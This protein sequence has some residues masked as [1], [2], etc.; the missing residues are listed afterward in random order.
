LNADKDIK[1]APTSMNLLSNTHGEQPTAARQQRCEAGCQR[2]SIAIMAAICL[3]IMV[4]LLSSI[5]IGYLFYMKRDLQKVADLAALAGAQQLVSTPLTGNPTACVATDAPVLAAI[6]NAQTN[7]FSTAAP[8]KMANVIAVTCGLWD[9]V[10]NLA[11]APNYFSAPPAGT[12]LNAVKVVVTQT[13][14]AFFGLGGRTLNAQAIASGSSPIAAFSLGTGLL[15]LCSGSGSLS[16]LLV[17]S[18]LGS[19]VCLNAVSYSGLLGAQVSL[20]Q[21]LTNLNANIGSISAVADT[22]I[23]L[24]QLINASIKGLSPVQVANIN[25]DLV[26]LTTGALGG[27]LLK[28]GDILDLSAANGVAALDTQIN[29]LDLLNVGALQVANKNNFLS[30]NININLGVLGQVVLQLSLIDA[31]KMAVGGPGATATSAQ[32]RLAINV[33]ALTLFPGYSAVQLPVYVYLAAGSARLNSLQCNAPQSA[34]FDI[35]TST[36]GI[37]VA[38]GQTLSSSPSSCPSDMATNPSSRFDAIAGVL[39]LGINVSPIT[40]YPSVTLYPP[41]STS[42]SITVGSS[43]QDILGG[44]IQPQKFWVGLDADPLG[45]L[46]GLLTTLLGTLGTLLNPLLS[47]V[48]ALLDQLT[49]LLGVNLGLSTLNLYSISCGNVKLVY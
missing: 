31:P 2:G 17:N 16:A 35:K 21:V 10:A 23:T 36:A 5:D 8:N 20:L 19:N 38:K 32:L 42:N 40:T 48:G 25:T 27:T 9:P 14:P 18:L 33:Q 46:S 39:N 3:S 1:A 15:T 28:I 44:V 4:I 13:V 6:G 26:N 37:C 7:G 47:G 24:A 11:L 43:L 34:N 45:L 41:P 22:Q 12:Q 30:S 49:S 29:I